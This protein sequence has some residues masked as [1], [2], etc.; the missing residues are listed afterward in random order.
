[1]M[2]MSISGILDEE[3]VEERLL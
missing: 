1:L 3:G 2:C